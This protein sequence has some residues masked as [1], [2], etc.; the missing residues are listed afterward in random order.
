MDDLVVDSQLAATVVDDKHTYRAASVTESFVDTLKQLVLIDD[1]E[2]LLDIT[3][4]GHGNNTA[5]TTH[6]KDA[7]LLED[8]AKHGLNDDTGLRVGNKGALLV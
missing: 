4:L 3:S 1:G 8:G 5:V 6:V 7:V 2:T